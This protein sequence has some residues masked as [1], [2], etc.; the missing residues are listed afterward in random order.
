ML[1]AAGGYF[2]P[3]AGGS[4]EIGYSVIPEARERGYATELVE[5]L[6]HVWDE[7]RAAA[8]EFWR[9]AADEARLSDDMRRASATNATVVAETTRRTAS[10]A[11]AESSS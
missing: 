5:A 4:V 8:R 9:A 3:P 7:A 6:V 1:V 11:D 2:G 10:D